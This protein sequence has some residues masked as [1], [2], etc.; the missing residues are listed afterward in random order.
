V[1][2]LGAAGLL[3]IDIQRLIYLLRAPVSVSSPAMY[4]MAALFK[5]V[6]ITDGAQQAGTQE[7][8]ATDCGHLFRV[9]D[10]DAD[11]C[12]QDAARQIQRKR[13][14]QRA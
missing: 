14:K 6:R 3:A 7:T 11:G 1:N 13:G 9:D 5:R 12:A 10:R 2:S 8:A 4:G